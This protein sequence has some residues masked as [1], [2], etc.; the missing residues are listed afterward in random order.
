[1]NICT[2]GGTEAILFQSTYKD[3]TKTDCIII[4]EYQSLLSV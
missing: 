1:M 2:F 4:K 3:M